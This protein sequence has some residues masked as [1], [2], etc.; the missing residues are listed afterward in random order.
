MA[1]TVAVWSTFTIGAVA[2]SV[3]LTANRLSVPAVN[4]LKVIVSPLPVM[5]YAASNMNRKPGLRLSSS[6]MNVVNAGITAAAV[7]VTDTV[8]CPAVAGYGN[9]SSFTRPKRSNVPPT[10]SLSAVSHH[11]FF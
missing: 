9:L 5:V 4:A 7:P 10:A 2:V 1:V 11:M 8:Y 3:S 6:E